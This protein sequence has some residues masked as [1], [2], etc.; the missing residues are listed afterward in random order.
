MQ[1]TTTLRID[2]LKSSGT[3]PLSYQMYGIPDQLDITY[4]GAS[5]FSTNGLVSG[6]QSTTATFGGT[7][8]IVEVKITAP[9]VG[10]AWDVFV[11][12]PQ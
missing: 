7:S 9:N 11:G 3:F 6:S 12:C 5:I 1:G 2:M 10:T 8:T 4:E